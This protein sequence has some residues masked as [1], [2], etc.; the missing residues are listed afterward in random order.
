MSLNIG[1]THKVARL[2]RLCPEAMAKFLKAYL[3]YN[4]NFSDMNTRLPEGDQILATSMVSCVEN[5]VPTHLC[6]L[7]IEIGARTYRR[8]TDGLRVSGKGWP[9]LFPESVREG[10]SYFYDYV[11]KRVIES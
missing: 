3:E 5:D 10:N 6:D 1:M 2:E 8:R 7:E 4:L 9:T 11:E